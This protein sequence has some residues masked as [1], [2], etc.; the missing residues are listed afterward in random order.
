MCG[1]LQIPCMCGL[2]QM[3]KL[4]STAAASSDNLSRLPG[5]PGLI[6]FTNVDLGSKK[7]EVMKRLSGSVASCLSKPESFVAVCV[8][9]RTPIA[10]QR[11]SRCLRRYA[12]ML[13]MLQWAGLACSWRWCSLAVVQ[14]G[15]AN[16]HTSFVYG[17]T[18][19]C[20]TSKT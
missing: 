16:K 14:L 6:L 9:V 18:A 7:V 5:D 19:V 12:S 8:N 13:Y 2:L 4:I 11:E 20:R 10:H 3:P 15:G 17:D 1:L